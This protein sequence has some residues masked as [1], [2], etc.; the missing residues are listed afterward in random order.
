MDE[1][2]DRLDEYSVSEVHLKQLV[3]IYRYERSGNE[4]PR[5][6]GVTEQMVVGEDFDTLTIG[7]SITDGTDVPASVSELTRFFKGQDLTVLM[8]RIGI[9]DLFCSIHELTPSEGID[10]HPTKAGWRR[11]GRDLDSSKE[12]MVADSNA[13]CLFGAMSA[14]NRFVSEKDSVANRIR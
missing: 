1:S 14:A 2:I 11:S 9:E 7:C 5:D 6:Y 3:E 12:A 8:T 13:E 4:F 10:L